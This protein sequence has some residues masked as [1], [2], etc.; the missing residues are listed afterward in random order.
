MCPV[1]R[2]ESAA[3]SGAPGF[4]DGGD[5]VMTGPQPAVQRAGHGEPE[6]GQVRV[7]FV[8]GMPRSGSTLLDLMAGQLPGHVAVGEVCYL[9]QA[10]P[11]RNQNCSCGVP[12]RDCPFW[13]A[14]GAVA[15]GGWE[16]L[17]L[18]HIQTLQDSVDRTSRL[19]LLLAPWLRPGFR[20]RRDEYAALLT[21]LYRGILQVSGGTTVVDSSKLPSMAFLLRSCPDVD[22]RLAHVVRDPR[23]VVHA[24]S[25]KVALPENSGPRAFLKTR[26]PLLMTRRWVSVNAMIGWLGRL[27][28]PR[29]VVRYEDLATD[30]HAALA[31][32][33][34]VTGLAP[35]E[36]LPFLTDEGLRMEVHHAATGGRVRF[37]RGT[38]PLRLDE[39]WRR[40]MPPNRQ[41]LV[42]LAT[43]LLR[44]GY[45]YR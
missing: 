39:A 17:D 21:R 40:D 13:T 38:M 41:R 18:D 3:Y 19:P 5:Q 2:Q 44:R 32:V 15:F 34:A 33:L 45:G 14:V 24:W 31:P 22:L 25:K 42:S 30:P 12:F 20:S 26:S 8:A 16:T 7:L 35:E 27:G 4:A 37:Q 36:P 28:V 23:A 9:W 10:G 11:L 43:G 29:A 6:P 1:L